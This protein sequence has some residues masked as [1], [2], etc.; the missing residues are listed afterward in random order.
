MGEHDHL[1]AIV[2][3]VP[4]EVLVNLNHGATEVFA[5]TAH[6]Q[7]GTGVGRPLGECLAKLL[8]IPREEE[9]AEFV[10]VHRIGVGR[11]GDPEVTVF[12]EVSGI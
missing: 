1:H 10:V 4:G 5:V 9:I 8:V 6:G 7:F 12:A 11:V 3:H 2:W